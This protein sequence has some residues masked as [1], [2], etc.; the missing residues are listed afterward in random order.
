MALLIQ[1]LYDVYIKQWY[2]PIDWKIAL[3]FKKFVIYC[4]WSCGSIVIDLIDLLVQ[5]LFGIA[6][7]I[8][9]GTTIMRCF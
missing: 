1:Q 7:K 2:I 3:Y 5:L 6:I 4:H 9:H 8:S